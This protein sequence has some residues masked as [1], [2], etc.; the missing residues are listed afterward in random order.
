[1][2]EGITL[3]ASDRSRPEAVVADRNSAQQRVW[4]ARIAPSNG[5]LAS[6]VV[7][8]QPDTPPFLGARKAS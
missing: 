6:F 5:T 2:G 1:M 3:S 8:P 7:Q 4:R